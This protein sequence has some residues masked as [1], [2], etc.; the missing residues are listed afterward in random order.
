MHFRSEATHGTTSF[1]LGGDEGARFG[2]IGMVAHPS[3]A[4][5]TS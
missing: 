4:F 2:A 3:R 1:A 5:T